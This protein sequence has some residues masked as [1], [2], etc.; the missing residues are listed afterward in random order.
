MPSFA[1]L[2][3]EFLDA[4]FAD[5]PVRASGLGLTEYDDQLD[6]LSESAF[7]RRRTRDSEWLERFRAVAPD[8]LSFDEAIDRDLLISKTDPTGQ[9]ATFAHNG[10]GLM[11]G[12]TDR[13]GRV[14]EFQY[15]ELYQCIRSANPILHAMIRSGF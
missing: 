12:T 6:D 5:A 8:S 3:S 2:S 10:A 4:E 1:D 14:R 13:S 11:T 9:T 7:E 15:D